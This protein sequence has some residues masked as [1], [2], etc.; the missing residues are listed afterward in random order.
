METMALVRRR[1]EWEKGWDGGAR[2][3]SARFGRGRLA[4]GNPGGRGNRNGGTAALIG[5][6]AALIGRSCR[7]VNPKWKRLAAAIDLTLD[8]PKTMLSKYYIRSWS[9]TS[10][11]HSVPFSEINTAFDLM[12][13]GKS[14]CCIIR[15][16][17]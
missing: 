3:A 7:W 6:E 4:P 14:L 10:S 13:S 1:R 9:W 8:R 17:D 2:R 16:Q 11:S 12:L 15:M 5:S